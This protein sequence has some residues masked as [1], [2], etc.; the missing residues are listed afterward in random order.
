[1]TP[2]NADAALA[3]FDR[4]QR[5]FPGS[6]A[7][8]PA[9]VAAG[10]TLRRLG[11][12][13]ESLERSDQVTM[14]YPRTTWASAAR[15]SSAACFAIGGR[16]LD[17]MEELQRVIVAAPD[18]PEARQA[19]M[20]NTIIYRL[21][22]RAPAQAPYR[23]SGNGIGGPTGRLK[24]V[25]AIA[26]GHDGMLFVSG[27]S[28]VLALDPKGTTRR[29]VSAVE[30]RALFVDRDGKVLVAQRALLVQEATPA[31]QMLTLTVPREGGQAR[32]LDEITAVAILSTGERL[33]AD[34]EQR[35]VFKFDAA[36]K[37]LGSFAPVRASRIALGPVE[38]V[39]LLDRDNKSVALFDRS[40]KPA[41][42]VATKGTGYELANP[43]DLAFDVL[44]HL[45]VL[46]G[47]QVEVFAPDGR[48][49][50][51]F[52]GDKTTTG[53]LRAGTALAL[54]QAARLYIY[55]DREERVQIY[56]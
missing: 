11:R 46:D 49:V 33:V 3:S 23:F 55:D 27:K 5:L 10:D 24:D 34:R 44:G 28:G 8:A 20:L 25:S 52:T 1:M 18:S 29:S 36:G 48:L 39:A 45:Y 17:A 6:E 26:L 22:V 56:Q 43:A 4:V 13:P 15:V 21:Y 54:D 9:L 14:T 32:V 41:G 31:P 37:Y 42:R 40:G 50:A 7:V 16:P 53:A 38:Q 30:P 47:A 19:R 35:G 51:I 2:A 12:C